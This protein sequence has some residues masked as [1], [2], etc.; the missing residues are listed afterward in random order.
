MNTTLYLIYYPL[1]LFTC[2]HPH[3]QGPKKDRQNQSLPPARRD[4]P[5]RNG[6][7]DPD[8]LLPRASR[9]SKGAHQVPSDRTR[10]DR[11]RQRFGRSA[12]AMCSCCVKGKGEEK[13]SL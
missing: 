1:H 5:D 11:H 9:S 6:P 10:G 4:H 3:L 8:P 7:A 13:L 2:I 12:L